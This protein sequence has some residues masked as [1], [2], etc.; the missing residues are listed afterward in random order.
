MYCQKFLNLSLLI[1]LFSQIS[2]AFLIT[3]TSPT[4]GVDA[5][6]DNGNAGDIYA[7]EFILTAR[8]LLQRIDLLIE[9]GNPVYD[10]TNLR[11]AIR[12][13]EVTSQEKVYLKGSDGLYHERDAV[14]L[15]PDKRLIDVSRSRWREFR[16]PGETKGRLRLVLHEYLWISGVDDTGFV[17]SDH[18]LELL[19]VSNYS[20]S[21][22]WNP[23]N[24]VNYLRLGLTFA[25][26]GCT[27]QPGKF[28]VKQPDETLTLTPT[29][30]CG[31]EFRRV[32]IIKSTG[33]TPPSSNIRGYFHKFEI[34]IFDKDNT[35]KGELTFEPEWG[36]CLVP[37]S[38][39]C[40]NS[41]KMTVGGVDLTFWFMRN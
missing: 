1:I 25:T 11:A 18:L 28:D 31:I 14:N 9:A 21:I 37:E 2:Y 24:P 8:D 4:N 32:Q 29:G 15:Y 19:N 20:P 41:G 12:S 30:P 36:A 26:E 38:G 33:V 22:W 35:L 13:T 3:P 23:V 34:K 6:W 39:V 5:G 16:R 7:S 40:R 10:T 27:F 17:H